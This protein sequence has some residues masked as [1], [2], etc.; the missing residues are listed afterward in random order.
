VLTTLGFA[1]PDL[2]YLL[3]NPPLTDPTCPYHALSYVSAAAR[4]AGFGKGRCLDANIE[5][6]NFVAQP[7]YVDDLLRSADRI[8]QDIERA[9]RV[10]TRYEELHSALRTSTVRSG[11]CDRPRI[12]TPIP[13]TRRPSTR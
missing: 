11:S 3:I 7:Q 12:S 2:P 5:A 9:G 8:R 13:P 6:L 10:P 1:V 4:A